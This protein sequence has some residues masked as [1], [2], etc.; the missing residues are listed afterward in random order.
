MLKER[1]GFF[2]SS[3]F[4][5]WGFFWLTAWIFISIAEGNV[6]TATIW[7]CVI[8]VAFIIEDKYIDHIYPKMKAKYREKRPNIF[9]KILLW[10][11]GSASFKSSLYIFYFVMLICFAIVSAEPN[12][13]ILSN[14]RYYF[15][16][17]EYGILILF[18][19]DN[20]L[21]QLFKDQKGKQEVDRE[22][23]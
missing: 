12:F 13:P 21:K 17:L 20:F 11:C 23:I 1:L 15:Q 2:I 10:Y 4:F 22:Q 14:M 19:G 6:L 3:V 16:S 9:Q 18:A 7:N 5:A 8:I